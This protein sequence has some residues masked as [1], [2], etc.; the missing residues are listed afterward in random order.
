MEIIKSARLHAPL[1]LA[2]KNH[3]ETLTAS[4]DLQILADDVSGNLLV[5]YGGEVGIVP[6]ASVVIAVPLDQEKYNQV[7][8]EA[9]KGAEIPKPKR[10]H[11]HHAQKLDIKSAQVS[12]PT[13]NVQNP[14]QDLKQ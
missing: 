8:D 12:D 10:T 1:F 2:G 14:R 5:R 11:I 6:E 4:A 7:F 13:T 3:K 9:F